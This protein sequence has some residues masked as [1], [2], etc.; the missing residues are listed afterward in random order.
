[1]ATSAVLKIYARGALVDVRLRAD[2]PALLLEGSWPG[3][4]SPLR[5]SLDD[6]IDASYA[7]IDEEASRLAHELAIADCGDGAPADERPTSNVQRPTSNS[8]RGHLSLNVGRWTLDVGRSIPIPGPAYLYQL[9]LRYYLVKL[10][11]VVA[12]FE[13]G[14]TPASAGWP[15]KDGPLTH[16]GIELV[17]T[18]GRDEDYAELLGAISLA[19]GC[20][21]VVT[22]RDADKTRSASSPAN[23]W[24]RRAAAAISSCTNPSWRLD[25]APRVVLCGSRRVLASVCD[26]LIGRGARVA[27]LY[28]RF[29]LHTWLR[30][31]MAG[32]AQLVCNASN[33]HTEPGRT[34]R[35][36]VPTAT[37]ARLLAAPMGCRGIDLSP[38]IIRW[39]TWTE[40]ER[41]EQQ[42]R[43]WRAIDEHFARLRPTALVLDE[44]ATPMARVAVAAARRHA[45]PSVVVQHG[46]PRVRFGF[47]PLAADYLFAWGD[48][49]R[50]QLLRWGVP[51]ERIRVVG[52]P[53]GTDRT[54]SVERPTPNVQPRRP[55]RAKCLR[56]PEILL[57]GTTPPR[58][59]RPDAAAFHL[60]A[61]THR[62]MLWMAFAA[63]ASIVAHG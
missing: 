43:L 16:A 42:A 40:H 24:W 12:F 46:V 63:V 9:K 37:C 54:S 15:R 36:A 38:S 35:Q 32:V 62:Q 48:S 33:N 59:D 58:D 4:T 56:Q 10:L 19:R 18:R 44:D 5:R 17:A 6:S 27:W 25:D 1:M 47:A 8:R 29:A 22:W 21:L 57:F 51:P 50:R 2:E 14:Q 26:E 41:G 7:W 60:N 55:A 45:V 53:G 28:D 39:L 23:R 30:W 34:D 31:R 49:S 61:R 52:W 11:R 3:G 13:K 20:R